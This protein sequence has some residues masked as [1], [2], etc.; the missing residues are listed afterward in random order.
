MQI[1]ITASKA[2]QLVYFVWER[3]P[4]LDRSKTGRIP[5]YRAKLASG[6][7]QAVAKVYC[8]LM[9][10]RESLALSATER[11]LLN[12]ARETLTTSCSAALRKTPDS[13]RAI[14]SAAI[15]AGENE[16]MTVTLALGL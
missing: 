14:L 12:E 10:R 5:E 13:I 15:A 9:H 2:V 6:D 11:N 16:S 3:S 7:L 8:D 4:I 1:E